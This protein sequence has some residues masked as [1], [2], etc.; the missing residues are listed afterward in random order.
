M[1]K[2]PN[3]FG[4]AD[5]TGGGAAP[6]DDLFA[7]PKT[8]TPSTGGFSTSSSYSQRVVSQAMKP[9]TR[10]Q[11]KA[12]EAADRAAQIDSVRQQ[13]LAMQASPEWSGASLDRRKELY[14][15][16]KEQ[17]WD[18]MLKAIEDPDLQME[19]SV[20]PAET[21]NADI[22][23]LE[24][25][26]S[27]ASRLD[28]TWK[29]VKATTLQTAQGFGDYL[30]AV[31]DQG[32]ITQLRNMLDNDGQQVV[33]GGVPQVKF[34]GSPLI[35]QLSDD[36]RKKIQAELERLTAS[37]DA[38]LKEAS[39]TRK[40]IDAIR[41]SQ[42]I[43]QIDR[44]RELHEDIEN[45][46]GFLGTL[47]NVAAHP[48]NG[49]QLAT[50][51]LPNALPVI[52]AATAGTIIGGPVGG[53]GAARVS[54][55]ILSAQDAMSSAIQQVQQLSDEELAKLKSYQ[56]LIQQ[57]VDPARAKD[58]LALR[59]GIDALGL[60]AAVGTVT[61]GLG[62]ESGLGR[63][64]AAVLTREA[65]PEAASTLLRTAARQLPTMGREMAVEGVEEGGTQFGANVAQNRQAGTNIDLMNDVGESAAQGI[66]ASGPLSG[67]TAIQETRRATRNAPS[68]G[69]DTG[70]DAT[71]GGEPNAGQPG[72]VPPQGNP[73]D[74]NNAETITVPD[75]A[76]AAAAE[77]P[78]AEAQ[79]STE[80]QSGA[81]D[82]STATSP[83]E[84]L[85]SVFQDIRS[86]NG[87]AFEA[88]EA[89][90][91]IDRILDAE[92]AG[93]SP[94]VIDGALSTIQRVVPPGLG[95][96]S[97]LDGLQ[98]RRAARAQ[99]TEAA[100]S[101]LSDVFEQV[102]QEQAQ[103][104]EGDTNGTADA[105]TAAGADAATGAATTTPAT[106]AEIN[107]A[108]EAAPAAGD[109]TAAPVSQPA[110][111]AGG[112]VEDAGTG[113]ARGDN[114]P[115][116]GGNAEAAAELG[117]APEGQLADSRPDNQP[118]PGTSETVSAGERSDAGPAGQRPADDGGADSSAVSAP[119]RDISVGD[120]VTYQ[121]P[122]RGGK[123]ITGTVTAVRSDGSF[124]LSANGTTYGNLPVANIAEATPSAPAATAAPEAAV[125]PEPAPLDHQQEQLG[126]SSEPGPADVA[127][128]TASRGITTPSGYS[129]DKLAAKADRVADSESD[130]AFTAAELSQALENGDYAKADQLAQ[131]L[132]EQGLRQFAPPQENTGRAARTV[133]DVYLNT[134]EPAE[135]MAMQREYS[136]MSDSLPPELDSFN[137]FRDAAVQD[138]LLLDAGQAPV[139]GVLDRMGQIARNIVQKMAKALAIVV[140]AITINQ[141]TPI[142]DATAA[143]GQGYVQQVQQV[144][145]LS[146][147]A[148]T[149][150][151]WVQ[152]SKDNAGR[153]YIIADKAA[154]EIHIV[155]ADGRVKATAPALY[156]KK[157]GDGMTL[158]ETPAGIFTVHQEAAPSSYGGDLQQFATAPNGD[159][160]AIHRVLTT[161]P[162]QN[163]L[164]RLASPTADD[165][166]V[167]LGCINIPADLYNKYL[168][169]NFNG[170]LYVLPDQ[171]SL[172]DVFKG[173]DQ[174]R[175]QANLKQGET[176][177]EN[178]T[179]PAATQY[180]SSTETLAPADFHDTGAQVMDT[181]AAVTA[182]AQNGDL[183]TAMS[184]T[185][186]QANDP[187]DSGLVFAAALPFL[188]FGRNQ[189]RS[190]KGK[191]G[192]SPDSTIPPNEPPRS[193]SDQDYHSAATVL[194]N[195]KDRVARTPGHYQS[196]LAD[197]TG[198][199]AQKLSDSHHAFISWMGTTGLVDPNGEFDNHKAIFDLKSQTNRMR[200]RNEALTQ[201]YMQPIFNHI[202]SVAQRMG[203][204]PD[205]V[206]LDM[207]SWQTFRHI[208]EAN[209][210][211]RQ[212]LE[213][214]LNNIMLI[215]TDAEVQAAK[216]K[217]TA[218]DQVQAGQ[219]DIAELKR[220][221]VG[222]LAG[223]FTDAQARA[224]IQIVESRGYRPEDLMEFRRLLFAARDGLIQE[225]VR[226]GTLLQEEVDQWDAH[227]FTEYVPLY[228]NHE[229][230]DA[231]NDVYLGTSNF[232][233]AGDYTRHGSVTPASHAMITLQQMLY[234]TAAGIE[235][236]PFKEDLH[237]MY[238][239]SRPAGLER[240]NLADNKMNPRS[241][242]FN[243]TVYE[244]RGFV[245]NVRGLDE[246]GNPTITRYKYYFEDDA[247]SQGIFDNHAEPD[248]KVAKLLGTATN[249]FGRM[250]TKYNPLFPIKTW[251]RDAGERRRT[252]ASRKIM[253]AD[254]NVIP[255]R[256]AYTAMMA[257]LYN[258]VHVANL[259]AY[260]MTGARA[261]SPTVRNYIELQRMGGV[262]TYQ[263]ALAKSVTD[264]RSTLKSMTG[265]RKHAK[266]LDKFF[267]HWN[268]M[269]SAAP[270]VAGYMALRKLGVPA[271]QASF[272]TLDVMNASNKG[273][274]HGT[275]SLFYPFIA[276]TFEGGRNLLRNLRTRR[277][278]AVFAANVLTS[279][280]LYSMLYGLAESMAG[281]DDDMGNM[282]DNMPLS[283]LG[284]NIPLIIDKD[285][286]LKIPVAFGMSRISWMLGA[287]L[288]RWARGVDT[289]GKV[290]GATVLALAKELQPLEL[291]THVM[292]D[293][294][295]AG[296]VLS[297]APSILSP[298]L[299]VAM[300][301]NHFGGMIHSTAP[302]EGFAADSARSTTPQIWTD[303]AK[304]L[305]DNTNG[306]VDVYP[307]NI[308]HLAQAW[309]VGP[310][311][312][313]STAMEK[314]SL[315][316]TGGKLTSRQEIGPVWDAVGLAQFWDNGSRGVSR[317]YWQYQDKADDILRKYGQL[318]TAK[319]TKPGEA[320][321][322][323][324][325]RVLV[326]GGSP[327][328]A[329]LV[330]YA[331]MADKAREKENKALKESVK[332]FKSADLDLEMLAPRYEQHAM[333]E[334]QMMRQFIRQ[335]RG[336]E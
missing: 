263:H 84:D 282:L 64:L 135:R 59:A 91:F 211:L 143:V 1:A 149:V 101:S 253:D 242:V 62:A 148:S 235:S 69:T 221:G 292:A 36:D 170:K 328:E 270:A 179:S 319:G 321:V 196:S 167:S 157:L 130:H 113:R 224:G 96:S 139:S 258:P 176:L 160:Y 300:N 315:Y 185:A 226:N 177:P 290:M 87:T 210:A 334:E 181:G 97:I 80:A 203:L 61:G 92:E 191:K 227:G 26:I 318:R 250:L 24:K 230:T 3:L 199:L 27:N 48:T 140:A 119:G 168:S 133:N 9:P 43:G 261:D 155:G 7:T 54:G 23:N 51:Q 94:T 183:S 57:G 322:A 225:R 105:D 330:Q 125:T 237:R 65:G 72:G 46:G 37:R 259:G 252:L 172:G 301:T 2:A 180:E 297:A 50:E 228:V 145:G 128:E 85:R 112:Y 4:P 222:G 335:A 117:A 124:D 219:R 184:F 106:V 154:G 195:Q 146:R 308:R 60:G 138:Q 108:M 251:W 152:E 204:S 275:L 285:N 236:V 17:R 304:A 123:P 159:I 189:R 289:P 68:E 81:A 12:R 28:D 173:V 277:G 153:P 186:A 111:Q 313:L 271:E 239:E 243:K 126:V 267:T 287:G 188:A 150:N 118:V 42:S 6:I 15:K 33:V 260:L 192:D 329:L 131:Y 171:R 121:P 296:L 73:G 110:E 18:P 214:E 19:L 314:Q 70:G 164:G 76:Q 22:K 245:Y 86:R 71:A 231:G 66:I 254:G 114:N 320:A 147:A 88:T 302:R 38:Q 132:Y 194:G 246:D 174:Q 307:E 323:A 255:L 212:T 39:E 324:Y 234:R 283:E 209:R 295:T 83:V 77:Q 233:P 120:T 29:G 207:G 332:K 325:R 79:P 316:T 208:P 78:T 298:L 276:P 268:E 220:V 217:L 162:K 144:Q 134:L 49:L 161:N 249:T 100:A 278:Q 218:L 269:W 310:L 178:F 98:Q 30:P 299:E 288:H 20:L 142:N 265:L 127:A 280:A 99:E 201:R 273:E 326:A 175:A 240:V 187:A 229:R 281:D 67:I 141:M 303:I 55:A 90:A 279:L 274:W 257:A 25:S 205:A 223:G 169:G 31:A 182:E 52:A 34:D 10:A 116:N 93:V 13:L 5:F 158:G 262:S 16:W 331:I 232:N 82:T 14:A 163:R 103:V 32:R 256:K 247:I 104:T 241:D 21:L 75:A 333:L 311:R 63:S 44:D 284:M 264:M 291:E 306:Y 238:S 309:L 206:G 166:R 200:Q 8:A 293:N 305:K 156:G 102:A 11:L 95:Y 74:I 115:E 40:D 197:L 312:G 107:S 216:D 244:K 272:R 151:S 165:N 136:E 193:V 58:E 215:G 56:Q 336:L 266:S 47:A 129:V 122:F 213:D 286:I 198:K 137:A 248:W 41:A 317:T 190:Q 202:V 45:R 35:Q 327:Q 53:V 89:N 109:T 294:V